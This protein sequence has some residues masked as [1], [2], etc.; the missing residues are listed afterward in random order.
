MHCPKCK[1]VMEYVNGVWYCDTCEHQ[2]YFN[3]DPLVVD[4][5]ETYE[6]D[7]DILHGK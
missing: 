7:E 2:E 4:E 1:D 3:G 6:T 5:Q